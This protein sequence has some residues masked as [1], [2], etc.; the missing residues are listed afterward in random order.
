MK[1][2][3][4]LA[5]GFGIV[6]TSAVQAQKNP[7]G[8]N[9]THFLCYRVSQSTA[10]KP[11]AA[12]LS[13]QFSALSTKIGKPLFLCNPVTKNDEKPQDQKTHLVCYEIS[14]KNAAKKVKV[15]NQF[16][17]QSLAI[18]GSFVLC[19]PSLKVVLK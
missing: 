15:T 14:A 18:G 16:G 10:L 11:T 6:L 5:V 9:P 3:I 13:D 12:K 19:V 17:S 8:V 4:I 7:E 2:S 1:T